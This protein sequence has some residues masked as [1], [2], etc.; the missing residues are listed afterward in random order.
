MSHNTH[1]ALAGTEP[2]AQEGVPPGYTSISLI[3]ALNGPSSVNHREDTPI[4]VAASAASAVVTAPVTPAGAASGDV[5]TGSGAPSRH[6]HKK[7]R[8]K[9][10][11]SNS[12]KPRPSGSVSSQISSSN[13]NSPLREEAEPASVHPDPDPEPVPETSG[14][15]KIK[16]ADTNV[17]VSLKIVNEVESIIPRSNLDIVEEELAKMA[18]AES[19]NDIPDNLEHVIQDIDEDL[20]ELD[21]DESSTEDDEAGQ[22]GDDELEE[23]LDKPLKNLQKVGSEPGTPMS[24]TSERSSQT[25]AGST[26]QL[27]PKNENPV[28]VAGKTTP[29]QH[30]SKIVM[31]ASKDDED[32]DDLEDENEDFC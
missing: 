4:P 2:L 21:E 24:H 32:L 27:L 16:S 28:Q 17:R 3:E 15:V 22:E 13:A 10:R 11:G 30:E 19:L 25:S 12:N 9:R 20:E 8:G 29:L 31:V 14:I 1:P 6:G 23:E 5:T 18:V 26:K 7:N